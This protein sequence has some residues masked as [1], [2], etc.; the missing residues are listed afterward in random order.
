M[1]QSRRVPDMTRDRNA[2]DCPTISETGSID[3]EHEVVSPLDKDRNLSAQNVELKDPIIQ[4]MLGDLGR[5]PDDVDGDELER[6]IRM[7]SM[8][9]HSKRYKRSL[10]QNANE[11]WSISDSD[12]N[13]PLIL[14]DDLLDALTCV[15]S[16]SFDTPPPINRRTTITPKKPRKVSFSDKLLVVQLSSHSM[17]ILAERIDERKNGIKRHSLAQIFKQVFSR[18]FFIPK[19]AKAFY[20]AS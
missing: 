12:T 2:S 19:S 18:A 17:D 15:N 1:P 3:W 14:A 13:G 16:S 9:K 20:K 10:I 5:N 8:L 4:E 11:Q 7:C 6:L